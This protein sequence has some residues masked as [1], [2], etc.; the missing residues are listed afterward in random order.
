MLGNRSA[1]A[2]R[3]GEAQLKKLTEDNMCPRQKMRIC[4]NILEAVKTGK[5]TFEDLRSSKVDILGK[6]L[7]AA[8]D[9][10]KEFPE[11][12]TLYALVIENMKNK[13]DNVSELKRA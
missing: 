7:S 5:Y 10:L 1:L 3:H 8:Y 6:A 9:C 13:L 4:R 12:E 2:L 11:E